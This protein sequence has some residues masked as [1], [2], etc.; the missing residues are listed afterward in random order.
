MRKT[1]FIFL[2]EVL[3]CTDVFI[4]CTKNRQTDSQM[5]SPPGKHPDTTHNAAGWK[6]KKKEKIGRRWL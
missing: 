6:E 5:V 4:D 2:D 1:V 3:V